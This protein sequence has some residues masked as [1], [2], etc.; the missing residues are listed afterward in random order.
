MKKSKFTFLCF[1]KEIPFAFVVMYQMA[2]LIANIGSR[3]S[4]NS[5]FVLEIIAE[6]AAE[7]VERFEIVENVNRVHVTS[8]M[9]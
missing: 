9:S 2:V 6:R 1:E 3:N 4:H 5:L 7:N 8:L